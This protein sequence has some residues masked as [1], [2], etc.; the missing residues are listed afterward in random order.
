[1]KISQ[2]C[3]KAAYRVSQGLAGEVPKEP[4]RQKYTCHAMVANLSI[5]KI[6]GFNNEKVL[7]GW[8]YIYY[9]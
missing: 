4:W 3:C 9:I 6:Y 8:L 1:M 7:D 5:A 2:A